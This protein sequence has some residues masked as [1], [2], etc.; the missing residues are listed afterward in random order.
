MKGL[1]GF[2][3]VHQDYQVS[4]WLV[5]QVSLYYQSY[6]IDFLFGLLE[7]YQMLAR[8]MNLDKVGLF[9]KS[10]FKFLGGVHFLRFCCFFSVSWV[11]MII[12]M[13]MIVIDHVSAHKSFFLVFKW[14][15]GLLGLLGILGIM[16]YAIDQNQ[17]DGYQGYQGY[18]DH[19][20]LTLIGCWN[21]S[22]H[23]VMVSRIIRASRGLL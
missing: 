18:Q 2:I 11:I 23:K 12:I 16:V 20:N 1:L 15:V 13:L 21:Y 22:A 8:V 3:G 6:C 10:Q 5:G 9:I 7:S 14:L 4:V 19:Y 17:G